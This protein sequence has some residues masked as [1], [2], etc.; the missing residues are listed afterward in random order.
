MDILAYGLWAGIAVAV[1]A[2]RWKISRGT[3]VGPVAMAVLP[4]FAQL[5]PLQGGALFEKDGV[6]VL[7][8]YAPA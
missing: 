5:L 7:G 1:A 3:A 2:R 4:D 8:T 6:A